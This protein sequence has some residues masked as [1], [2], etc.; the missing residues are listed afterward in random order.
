MIIRPRFIISTENNVHNCAQFLKLDCETN[1]G[2]YLNS[3]TRTLL[4]LP[5]AILAL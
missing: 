5:V 1:N 2:K 3:G 4:F